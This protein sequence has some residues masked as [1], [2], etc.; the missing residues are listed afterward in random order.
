MGFKVFVTFL[1]NTAARVSCFC[2]VFVFCIAGKKILLQPLKRNGTTTEH[3]NFV[4]DCRLFRSAFLRC[5][6]CGVLDALCALRNHRYSGWMGGQEISRRE[7]SR[8]NFG[9][10]GGFGFCGLLLLADYPYLEF[11]KMAVDLGRSNC[12]HQ[13]H[14]PN[15]RFGDIQKVRLPSYLG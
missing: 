12:R 7:Q 8:S 5:G 9:Q 13:T 4:Q 6:R 10:F 2:G 11:P 1:I 14:Q 15:L 3:H